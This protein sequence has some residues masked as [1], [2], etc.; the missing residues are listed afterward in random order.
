MPDKAALSAGFV[1]LQYVAAV[2][3]A[4]HS[5]TIGPNRLKSG[6]YTLVLSMLPGANSKSVRG[7]WWCTLR[8]GRVLLNMLLL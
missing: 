7:E 1:L 5:A 3:L 6:A 4:H 8:V 2:T